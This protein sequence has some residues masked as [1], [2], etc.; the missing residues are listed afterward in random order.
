MNNFSDFDPN[1]A[2]N[3]T[4]N[5]YGFPI[6]EEEAKVVIL[7][8]PWEVTVSYNAG[9]ARGTEHIFKA[10]MHVDVFDADYPHTWRKGYYMRPFDKKVLMKSDYL[11]KEAELYIDYISRGEELKKNA[12]MCKSL[13]D[14][15]EG[16]VF[17]NNWVF[18]Q[19]KSLMDKDKLVALLG[20]DHSISFGYMKAIGEKHGDFGVLQ[21][22]AH[23]DLRKSYEH[24]VYSHASIMYNALTE[25]PQLKKLV[26]LG[27]RDYSQEEW[28]YAQSN[29]NRVT[30]FFDRHIK[31]KL[32]EGIT[33][34]QI[35]DDIIN[36]L[37]QKVYVSFDIDGLD[38]KLCPNTGT[39]VHG[40]FE[41]DQVFYLLKRMLESGRQLIGFD[42]VEVGIG[43]NGWDSNVGARMLLKL[44]NLLASGNN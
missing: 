42:L 19:T 34:K 17:L 31:E 16:G 37:P 29:S 41:A 30:T 14:I 15:N 23:C 24:F 21:I 6:T 4:N 33:W 38:P 18:E 10:S 26:Q 12:F 25:I 1:C 44:C 8:V 3:P 20:G 5:I 11:R 22:D 43:E 28:D 9:T 7:P 27:V 40:G 13:K 39:P 36:Q 35:A 32:F 2:S